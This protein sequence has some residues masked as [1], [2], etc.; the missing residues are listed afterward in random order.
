[1]A[2]AIDSSPGTIKYKLIN[3]FRRGALSFVVGALVVANFAIILLWRYGLIPHQTVHYPSLAI[4]AAL[5]LIAVAI[6]F[7]LTSSA[8][9]VPTY[10]VYLSGAPG[11]ASVPF[12]EAQH[13]FSLSVEYETEDAFVVGNEIYARLKL[14]PNDRVPGVKERFEGKRLMAH[15]PCATFSP[16]DDP[17][18]IDA[19]V[20]LEPSESALDNGLAT[21]YH[22]EVTLKRT[23]PGMLFPVLSIDE[24]PGVILEMQACAVLVEPASVLKDIINRRMVL[25]FSIIAVAVVLL[26]LR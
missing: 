5:V 1:M 11:N 17:S 13:E 15:F 18:S 21:C 22:G 24:A 16:Q 7:G 12:D 2:R 9:K 20:N 3:L 19:H 25:G 23:Q 4:F 10:G 8:I 14:V 6:I 26:T